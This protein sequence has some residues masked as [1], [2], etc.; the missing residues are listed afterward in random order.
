ME[1]TSTPAFHRFRDLPNELRSFI[2]QLACRG[3]RLVQLRRKRCSEDGSPTVTSRAPIPT[4]LHVCQESR[5][6]ALRRYTLSFGRWTGKQLYKPRVYFDFK[7]DK[8]TFE[9]QERRDITFCQLFGFIARE[10]LEK[11]HSV[12]IHERHIE[13]FASLLCHFRSVKV[14]IV[15]GDLDLEWSILRHV[16]VPTVVEKL[17]SAG[18]ELILD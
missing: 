3:P 4:V 18:V 13:S 11:I 10:E 15:R 17:A 12:V 7:Q 8:I 16:L 1:Q 2:W 5:A 9:G 6:E 14:V